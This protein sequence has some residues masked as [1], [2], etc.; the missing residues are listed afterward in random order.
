MIDIE[1]AKKL[2]L[3]YT[4]NYDLKEERIKSKQTH[5]IRVMEVS[6]Q[7]AEGLKLEQEEIK[8]AMII[9]LL[10]DIARFDQYT[11]YKTYKD[12][13]SFDHG[14]YAVEIL[15]KDIRKY[16]ETDKYDTIILTAIKNHNKFRIEDNLNE[17]ELLFSKI[18][19]DADKIDIFYQ[20]VIKPW[21]EYEQEANISNIIKEAIKQ[22]K[23]IENKKI[24]TEIPADRVI[25]LIAFIF[26]IN[27]KISLEII[28]N[29]DYINKILDRF[30]IKS[31]KA[32]QDIEE[33]R[34]IANEYI[35]EQLR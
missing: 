11:Q 16:I 1:K 3:E 29:E 20:A 14:D 22:H 27:F 32:K 25:K 4:E 5:S 12:E 9:G 30:K 15:K 2:F 26:D 28:K 21:K 7:I 35:E 8:L 6:K 23:T 13:E 31:E 24:K 17:K 10:H 33:I 19:R 34:K 18:I